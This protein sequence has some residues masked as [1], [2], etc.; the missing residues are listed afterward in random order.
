MLKCSL[1]EKDAC[2]IIKKDNTYEGRCRFHMTL[3]KKE[4]RDEEK[5]MRK[6]KI[7]LESK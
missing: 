3:S 2:F 5:K 6:K 1:C 7:K 4:I